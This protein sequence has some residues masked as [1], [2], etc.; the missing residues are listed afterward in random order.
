MKSSRKA[1]TLRE[2]LIALGRECD[3]ED[4][5]GLL[6]MEDMYESLQLL[7]DRNPDLAKDLADDWHIANTA[8][9][10]GAL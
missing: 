5:E 9:M 2:L 10:E 7:G 8:G 4:C 6:D 1:K 3:L